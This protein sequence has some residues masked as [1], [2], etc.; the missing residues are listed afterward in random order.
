MDKLKNSIFDISNNHF[1]Y[2]MNLEN[3]NGVGYG[4]KYINDKNTLEPCIHVLVENK[5]NKNYLSKSNIIPNRY[6]GIKTDVINVGLV[7]SLS[8]DISSY[9]VTSPAIP[10]KLRPLMGCCCICQGLKS[11]TLGCIVAKMGNDDELHYY[12]VFSL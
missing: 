5:V 2:L 4:Y 10:Y 11:G 9:N 12:R 1:K 8:N 3:V 7:S 6:M